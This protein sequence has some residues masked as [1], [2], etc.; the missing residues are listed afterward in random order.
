M[1]SP[2]LLTLAVALPCPPGS[3][4]SPG[5]PARQDAAN[6]PAVELPDGDA[7]RAWAGVGADTVPAPLPDGLAALDAADAWTRPA[8]WERWGELV[9]AEAGAREADPERRAGL[10]LLALR[11]GRTR[12]A[13]AHFA[14]LGGSPEWTA[15]MLAL[16]LPGVPAGTELG[17][18]GV[19]RGL[20]D[21]SVLRPQLP[22]R[23]GDPFAPGIEWRS[24]SVRGVRIGE[25]T[26]D[27]TVQ[28]EG[29][30][31]QVDLL[32]VG[33]GPAKVAV[34]LPEPEGYRIHVEYND[35]FRQDTLREPL[36]VELE[37]G[38]EEVSLF[39]RLRERSVQFPS[40]HSGAMPFQIREGALWLA[41]ADPGDTGDEDSA[42]LESVATVLARLLEVRV[43]V[44][45]EAEARAQATFGTLVHLP[46]DPAG[47]ATS[48]RY[49]AASVERFRLSSGGERAPR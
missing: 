22:P 20:A 24:A 25:A 32:H 45:P 2:W 30:G 3:P 40:D 21:G 8:T 44:A 41:L 17:P 27:V 16:A 10:F 13:W 15:R 14:R 12:D 48:L 4:F 19:V 9:A 38:A 43:R 42:L 7:A 46:A 23:T 34:L 28:I 47:R 1:L 35:W 37:P 26:V 31:V 5:A 33:G 29:D 49:L 18:G 36:L 6:R 39:G 11:H